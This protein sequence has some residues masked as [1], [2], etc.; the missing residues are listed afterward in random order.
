MN[1]SMLKQKKELSDMQEKYKNA[2]KIASIGKSK[3]AIAA[4]SK[5]HQ[6]FTLPADIKFVKFRNDSS[7]IATALSDKTVRIWSANSLKTCISTLH[8]CVDQVMCCNFSNDGKMVLGSSL[9]T[10]CRIWSLDTGRVMLT[11]SGHKEKVCAADF[12]AD[13]KRLCTGSHDR[14]MKIFDLTKGDLVKTMA[15]FS[16]VHALEITKSDD[17]IVSGHF[18]GGIRIQ[19]VK[20]PIFF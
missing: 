7:M 4:P 12:S 19:Y 18:D 13:S 6:Q 17:M 9:D 20:N 16:P 14:T 11:L 2:G 8:G 5:A 1:D 3:G 10:I 15:C